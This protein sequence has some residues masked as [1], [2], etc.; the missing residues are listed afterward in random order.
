MIHLGYGPHRPICQERKKR[1]SRSVETTDP[2]SI[3]V[4]ALELR[5]PGVTKKLDVQTGTEAEAFAFADL[6]KPWGAGGEGLGIDAL[7]HEEDLV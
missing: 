2:T 6:D 3:R 4:W 5:A 7:W 1:P